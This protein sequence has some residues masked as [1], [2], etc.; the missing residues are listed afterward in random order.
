MKHPGLIN[1]VYNKV[2]EKF[3][4]SKENFSKI[5]KIINNYPSGR[6]QSAV[7]PLLDLAQR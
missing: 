1:K 7:I 5:N 6:Q 4:W 2:N 3:E